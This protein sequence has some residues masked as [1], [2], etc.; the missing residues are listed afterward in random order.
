M[1]KALL[2]CM[3]I[4]LV[5]TPIMAAYPAQNSG[6]STKSWRDEGDCSD[7]D[8]P[9][10]CHEMGY[11]WYWDP[12][13]CECIPPCDWGYHFDADEWSCIP[14]IDCDSGKYY[15]NR[16]CVSCPTASITIASG[17]SCDVKS[18]QYSDTVTDCFIKSSGCT[19]SDNT[20][21]YVFTQDCR[22]KE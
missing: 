15:S 22:Y 20:G 16:Q 7:E 19:Y 1:K 17:T 4:L 18:Y 13:Y 9:G 21:T 3:T 12:D 14:D 11:R 6:Y 5:M 8:D 2:T 10:N